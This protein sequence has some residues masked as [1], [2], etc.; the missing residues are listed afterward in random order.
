VLLERRG[1]GRGGASGAALAAAPPLPPRALHI[2][3]N[4][5]R[6]RA[7]SLS[8][9]RSALRIAEEDEAEPTAAD[10]APPRP[11]RAPQPSAIA[12]FA[13]NAWCAALYALYLAGE[14]GFAFARGLASAPRGAG[15]GWSEALARVAAAPESVPRSQVLAAARFFAAH[16][17]A[18]VHLAA[19]ALL[20]AAAQ[21]F[22]YASVARFGGFATTTITVSRKFLSVLLSVV[23]FG[24]RLSLPQWVGVVDVFAGFGVQLF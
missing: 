3:L 14:L 12:M 16:P 6:P 15:E 22:I 13:M 24:H 8:P 23:L 18:L 1:S 17:A 21:I 20:G 19:F 4:S 9:P 11:Q 5:H 7:A 2:D 10:A